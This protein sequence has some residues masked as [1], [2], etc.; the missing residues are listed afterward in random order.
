LSPPRIVT[1]DALPWFPFVFAGAAGAPPIAGDVRDPGRALGTEAIGLRI[2]RVPPGSRTS[3][4]HRHLFQEELLI[5]MSGSGVLLHD[6]ERVPVKPGDCIAY[7]AGDQAAHTFENTGAEPLVIWAFGDR[8]DHEV[9]LYPD[10]G[11]AFVE[12]LGGDVPLATVAH[13]HPLLDRKD[14]RSAED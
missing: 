12:G 13:E 9:C 4:R 7:R 6:A 11:M 8:R 14:W 2:Q 3:R 5:V 10:E 1:L